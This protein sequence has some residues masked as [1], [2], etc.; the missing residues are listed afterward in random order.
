MY[1][2]ERF[3]YAIRNLSGT[4]PTDKFSVEISHKYSDGSAPVEGI[5]IPVLYCVYYAHVFPYHKFVHDRR[6]LPHFQCNSPTL[7]L[8]HWSWDKMDTIFQ[9]R[10]ST[11]FSWMKMF[12][13]RWIFDGYLFRR[14]QL[15]TYQHWYRKWRVAVQAKRQYLNQWCLVYWRLYVSLGLNESI[16]QLTW[17]TNKIRH[18]PLEPQ[19]WYGYV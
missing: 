14:V 9:T 5:L 1:G 2:F 8:T 11:A 19:V 17:K 7:F 3:S 6:L 4:L 13:F 12:K 15:T 16:G 10:F 18:I